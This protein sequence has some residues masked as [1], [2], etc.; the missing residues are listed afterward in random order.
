ME[1]DISSVCQ[2]SNCTENINCI[3]HNP[4]KDFLVSLISIFS[5]T[6]HHLTYCAAVLG[7]QCKLKLHPSYVKQKRV[8]RLEC[9]TSYL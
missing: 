6:E 2:V 3:R 1:K 8:I 5:L 4:N 9:K 7:S